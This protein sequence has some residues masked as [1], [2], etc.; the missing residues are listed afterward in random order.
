[1]KSPW[2]SMI[3]ATQWKRC[4]RCLSAGI[5]YPLSYTLWMPDSILETMLG[6]LYVIWG[7]L[8]GL[9]LISLLELTNRWVP[10]RMKHEGVE[11][12]T[13]QRNSRKAWLVCAVAATAY[14]VALLSCIW[15]P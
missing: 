3:M 5:L 6:P 12:K 10:E 2:E 8:S 9:V 1:M 7:F 14:L 11:W 4:L 13:P 15:Q